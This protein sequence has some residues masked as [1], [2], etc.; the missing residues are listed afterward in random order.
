LLPILSTKVNLPVILFNS[1]NFFL[2][3]SSII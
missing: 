1:M 3:F 2:G